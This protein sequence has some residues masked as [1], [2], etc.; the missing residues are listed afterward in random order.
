MTAYVV[1]IREKTLDQNELDIYAEKA[2]V[3]LVGLQATVLSAYQRI[4]AF[5]GEQPEGAVI[6]SFPTFEDATAWY[7]GEAYQAIVGHR[8]R[9]AIYRG[10]VVDGLAL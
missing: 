5:E 10:F 9:G 3:A 6:F 4:E 7:H 1:F 8:H 2:T